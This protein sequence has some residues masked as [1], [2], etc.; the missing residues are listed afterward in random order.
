MFRWDWQ[1]YLGT[2]IEDVQSNY[3]QQQLVL[4]SCIPIVS[5]LFF[6]ILKRCLF[7]KKT[8]STPYVI[9]DQNKCAE[10]DKDTI[11][12]HIFPRWKTGWPHVWKDELYKY[13]N[14]LT[15]NQNSDNSTRRSSVDSG[16]SLRYTNGSPYCVKLEALLT[17]YG[18]KYIVEEGSELSNK[19]KAPS[20]E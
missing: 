9:A 2:L 10:Y 14:T 13:T 7:S 15:A 5:I 19:N 1:K 11:I 8:Q 16:W 18:F 17:Y 3:S 6:Y 4:Y 12:L 20:M